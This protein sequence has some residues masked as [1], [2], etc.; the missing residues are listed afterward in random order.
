MSYRY[1]KTALF[2]TYVSK[3][4]VFCIFLVWYVFVAGLIYLV[5][6]CT[7][8]GYKRFKNETY[9]VPPPLPPPKE[10]P[11]PPMLEDPP[12]PLARIADSETVRDNWLA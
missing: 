9:L 3:S 1:K 10:P 5:Y 7:S 11:P 2:D 12:P 6:W 8:V 4:A